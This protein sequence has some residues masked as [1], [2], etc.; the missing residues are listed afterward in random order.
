[1]SSGLYK[2]LLAGIDMARHRN[3]RVKVDSYVPLTFNIRAKVQVETSYILED[4]FASV[5]S[6]LKEAFSFA[7]RSFGQAVTA[8]EVLAIMQSAKGVIAVDLDALYLSSETPDRHPRLPRNITDWEVA[9]NKPARL[10]T[11]NPQGITLTEMTT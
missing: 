10:L 4:V 11:V 7:K 6:A 9:I 8:S 1:V 5:K 2:N 3:Y